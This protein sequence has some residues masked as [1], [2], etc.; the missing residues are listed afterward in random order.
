MNYAAVI[1]VGIIVFAVIWWYV[2]GRH[3]YIGPRVKAT[4]N[5]S[6]GQQSRKDALEEKLL[7]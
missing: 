1:L 6:V 2:S 3:F 7:E 4:I 5:V